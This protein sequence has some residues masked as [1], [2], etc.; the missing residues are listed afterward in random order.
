[1]VQNFLRI[2]FHE[3]PAVPDELLSADVSRPAEGST[4]AQD[5]SACNGNVFQI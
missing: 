5:N 1:M 2:D 3:I 4:R